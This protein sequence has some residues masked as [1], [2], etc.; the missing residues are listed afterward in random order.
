LR[1]RKWKVLVL[2]ECEIKQCHPIKDR[3]IKF[4]Q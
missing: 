4:L 3:L 1:E 2:W